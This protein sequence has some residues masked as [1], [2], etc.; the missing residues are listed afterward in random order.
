MTAAAIEPTVVRLGDFQAAFEQLLADFGVVPNFAT[1]DTAKCA[2]AVLA[3]TVAAFGAPTV[4]MPVGT[5]EIFQRLQRQV[6]ARPV[7]DAQILP[8]PTAVAS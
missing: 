4:E 8:F 2:P 7:T 5:E 3:L 6:G 1:A